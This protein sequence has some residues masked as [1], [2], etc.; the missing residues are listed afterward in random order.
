MRGTAVLM[1]ILAS[2]LPAHLL[3][4]ADSKTSA[5][6]LTAAQIVEKHVAARGGLTAWRAVQSLSVTGKLEAGTGDSMTRSRT[7]ALQGVGAS[8]KR[9]ERAA[10]QA[11]ASKEAQA[12]VQLP[13]RFEMKRPRKS[14]LEIDFAGKT[15]VQVYD[16]EHGWKLRPFLNRDD[17]EPF[18][19]DEAKAEAAKAD[20]EGPLLDYA[21]KGT[22]VALEATEPVDGHPAYKLKVTMKN[23]DVQHIWIDTQ[24]FLDV[25]VEGSPRRLDD[26]MR[27]VWIYQRDFRAVQGLMV[28]YLYETA[29]EGDHRTHRMFV[30][31]VTVNRALNDGRFTKPQVL[32]AD[33]QPPGAVAKPASAGK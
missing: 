19:E 21:A 12:Q 3:A 32:T 6:G 23:G 1:S 25:K 5:A 18:T 16:G 11:E 28:P 2:V 20:L 17:V 22:Q 15:A 14:R 30:E 10:A 31:S 33:S 8:V 27:S 29:I 13:F 9:A 26:K 7:L 4:A 24:S